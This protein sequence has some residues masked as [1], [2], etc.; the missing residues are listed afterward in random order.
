MRNLRAVRGRAYPR[1]VGANRE[2]SWVFFDIALPLLTVSAYAYIYKF[3]DPARVELVGYVILGGAMTAFWLNILWSMASQF[4]W[5]KEIGNLQLFLIA[6][7]S[8][9][10]ILAGMAVGGL[11]FT[12]V[13]A[14]A[15]LLIGIFIFS[16]S[17]SLQ[18][19]AMLIVVFVVTMIALYGMGMMFASLY[20][21]LGREAYHMSNLMTE[22]VYL[23]S[24]FYFPVKQLGFYV[25][26]GASFIP[27]TLG[28]DALR[29]LFFKTGAAD[30]FVSVELELLVL[31]VLCVVFMV[32][33]K[34]SLDYMEKL[35]KATGRLTLRWQ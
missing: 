30:G 16:V 5:E 20:L 6:P 4:Y 8:R 32:L 25:A 3:M 31:C 7:I 23:A 21:L 22:P 33:S 12:T 28:L 10:S 11:F 15:T 18:Q 9:M 17:F 34:L 27:I 19:P 2:P 29:Q 14:T 1:V 35:G 13:R 26:A 24:G